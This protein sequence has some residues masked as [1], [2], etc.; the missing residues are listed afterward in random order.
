MHGR[1]EC[2]RVWGA[3]EDGDRQGEQ[4]LPGSRGG[5]IKPDTWEV[6]THRQAGTVRE[7]RRRSI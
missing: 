2:L 3:Y 6:I 5:D 4:V 7:E 1:E